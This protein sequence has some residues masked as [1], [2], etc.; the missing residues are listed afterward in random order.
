MTEHADSSGNASFLY[1]E[2]VWFES[3]PRHRLEFFVVTLSPSSGR[4]PQIR[5]RQLSAVSFH[6]QYSQTTLSNRCC[7]IWSTDVTELSEILNM[8]LNTSQIS[9]NKYFV[10]L[11]LMCIHFLTWS[12][13]IAV[14]WISDKLLIMKTIATWHVLLIWDWG[15]DGG[16]YWG[17][18]SVGMRSRVVQ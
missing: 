17:L 11:L 2:G 15:C 14:H 3:R 4:V 1:S 18:R 9:N 10:N 8:S 5:S 6:I 13:N 12:Q 16:E 7:V